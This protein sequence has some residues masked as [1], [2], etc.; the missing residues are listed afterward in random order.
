M[1][2]EV[3]RSL[4]AACPIPPRL[5]PYADPV[6]EWLLDQLPRLGVPLDSSARER[7]DRAGFAR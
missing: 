6:Q 2:E 7:L 3:L 5:S 1:V 4:R